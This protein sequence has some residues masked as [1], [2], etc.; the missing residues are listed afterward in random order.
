M[1]LGAVAVDRKSVQKAPEATAARQ[2]SAPSAEI[3]T[4]A[5][6]GSERD[7]IVTSLPPPTSAK[8]K[9]AE[10][11]RLKIEKMFELAGSE[12]VTGVIDKLL[13]AHRLRDSLT[14]QSK[15][16]EVRD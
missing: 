15:D 5:V 2:T 16:Y 14:E 10:N 11:A 6:A 4:P 7:S 13:N 3:R 8:P 12:N 9:E 1:S